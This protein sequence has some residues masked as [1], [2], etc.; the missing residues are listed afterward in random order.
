METVLVVLNQVVIMLLLL[1]VGVLLFKVKM[2]NEEGRKQL[3]NIALYVSTSA[4]IIDSFLMD[5]NKDLA[6]NILYCLILAVI[7]H[8]IGIALVTLFI[9]KKNERY[10]VLRFAGVFANCG[11][12]GIPLIQAVLGPSGVIYATVFVTVFNV[13]VWTYGVI[14]CSGK[15]EKG[16]IKKIVLSPVLICVAIGLILFIF[17]IR[18]FAPIEKTIEYIADLNT[19]LAMI[20]TGACVANS[21]F[22]KAFLRKETYV[23]LGIRLFAVSVI[24]MFVLKLFSFVS[25]EVAMT[26]V[27]ISAAP[28]ASNTAMFAEKYNLGSDRAGELV[29]VSTILSLVSI[30]LITA[31]YSFVGAF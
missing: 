16:M 19:P 26:T 2:I 24:M 11:F 3:V 17:S 1:L 22:F 27:I 14:L 12:M 15:T 31:L 20:A 18:L 25:Y 13:F 4:V 23:I 9:R 6:L 5:F 21:N 29:V 8:T 10:Q 30:P 28:T 7:S